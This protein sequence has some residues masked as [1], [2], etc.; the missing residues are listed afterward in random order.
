MTKQK[1]DIGDLVE[2]DGRIP[3]KRYQGVVLD[4]KTINPNFDDPNR[5]FHVDEYHC[6][7]LI[8]NSE[9]ENDQR[10]VRT[11]WLKLLSKSS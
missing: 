6:K 4:R 5:L 11:K 10:W 8:L 1:I 2:V 7:V 3:G 9:T